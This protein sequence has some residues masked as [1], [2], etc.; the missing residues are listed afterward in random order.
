M[1]SQYAS[2]FTPELDEQYLRRLLAPTEKRGE[3]FRQR[4]FSEALGR[5]LQGDPFESSAVGGADQA[6]LEALANL[7]A[8]FNFQRAGLTRE[9]RLIGEGREFQ[10]GEAEKQRGFQASEAAKD[11]SLQNFL[12]GEKMRYLRQTGQD[13]FLNSLIQGAGSVAGGFLAGRRK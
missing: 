13:E 1:P 9:E 11:R 12:S 8:D 2:E 7:E 5:G 6:T 4:R 10:S 3:Q